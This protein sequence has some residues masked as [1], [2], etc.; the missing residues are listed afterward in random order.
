MSHGVKVWLRKGINSVAGPMTDIYTDTTFQSFL[1]SYDN[2]EAERL[3]LPV[4]TR[5]REYVV[6]AM[7]TLRPCPSRGPKTRKEP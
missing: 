6:E 3:G 1:G 7:L 4:V 2:Y 5:P